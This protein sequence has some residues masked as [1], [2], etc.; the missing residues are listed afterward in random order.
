MPDQP[1]AFTISHDAWEGGVEH[2]R[3]AWPNEGVGFFLGPDAATAHTF[4][5]A[6][7]VR[8]GREFIVDPHDQYRVFKQAEASGQVVVALVHSHPAG[9]TSLSLQDRSMLADW[10]FFHVVVAL[11]S[12][13]SVPRADAWALRGGEAT[14]IPFLIEGAPLPK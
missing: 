8:E 14:A 13:R 4:V 9:G 7:N 12:A 10:P 1:L 6:R 2:L 5:A 11:A 3:H